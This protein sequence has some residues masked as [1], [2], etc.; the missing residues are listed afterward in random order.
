ME[1]QRKH[2]WKVTYWCSS[3]SEP[4]RYTWSCRKR[5]NSKRSQNISMAWFPR[6]KRKYVR[7]GKEPSAPKLLVEHPTMSFI[8]HLKGM[9]QRLVTTLDGISLDPFHAPPRVWHVTYAWTHRP[10]AMAMEALLHP[11]LVLDFYKQRFVAPN[12]QYFRE[13]PQLV[14][15]ENYSNIHEV[16]FG[17]SYRMSS[18]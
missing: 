2:K 11:P 18:F 12:P 10:M 4:C 15:Q 16:S 3:S 13:T 5:G 9:F 17:I 7:L 8:P 14:R 6:W 1:P